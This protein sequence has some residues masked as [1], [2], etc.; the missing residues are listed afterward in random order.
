M[1]LLSP[2]GLAMKTVVADFRSLEELANT[3]WHW[4]GAFI[5][6]VRGGSIAACRTGKMRSPAFSAYAPG[7]PAE[8]FPEIETTRCAS[9]RTSEGPSS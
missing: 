7:W 8:D 6:P 5:S 9:R 3:S 1:G 2:R 4:A